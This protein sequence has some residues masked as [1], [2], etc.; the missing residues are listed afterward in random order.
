MHSQCIRTT[1]IDCGSYLSAFSEYGDGLKS[2]SCAA[3]YCP[4]TGLKMKSNPWIIVKIAFRVQWVTA[5]FDSGHGETGATVKKQ[6][7]INKNICIC[8]YMYI[9]VYAYIES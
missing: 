6:T 2:E 1:F 4:Y 7:K 8:V 3:G 9:Y 5:T